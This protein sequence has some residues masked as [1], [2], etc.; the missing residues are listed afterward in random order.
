MQSRS[1]A[2]ALAAIAVAL[3][4]GC[5]GG[6]DRA[7]DKAGGASAPVVLRLGSNDQVG[8][9]S[10]SVMRYFAAE[11]ARL[12]HGGLRL[13]VR[14]DAGGDRTPASE[15]R[16]I[17]GVQA[18]RFDLG[19]IGARAWDELGVHS[20]EALQAPFLIRSHALLD[21]V[22]TSPL[23][24]RMLAGLTAQDVVGLALVPDELRHPIGLK[25]P[26]VA[27]GDFRRARF[28]DIP[29]RVTDELLRALGARPVHVA[30]IA[31]SRMV[32]HRQLDGEE[33]ALDLAGS[34]SIVT[35][36]A[37]FFGKALTLFAGRKAFDSLTSEQQRVVRTA[38]ARTLRHTLA[39]PPWRGALARFCANN[40]RVVLSSKRQLA[41]LEQ[42]THPV[43]AELQRDSQ[44]K[45]MIAAIRRLKTM[46]R[47]D[48]PLL[49]PRGCRYRPAATAAAGGK[50][51]SPSIVNGT[52]HLLF[53]KADALSFGDPATQPENMKGYPSVETRVL[54]DGK[55]RF[56]GGL[57]GTYSIRGN[58]ITLVA[59]AFGSRES[60]TFSF[61]DGTLR[62]R[63]VLPMDRGDQW[64]DAGE[65]WHR[66]GPPSALP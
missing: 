52:Y 16:I 2:A 62:L 63:P 5:S 41:G 18:G 26:F 51:R 53:T 17:R 43:Y 39:N 59:P 54:N 25:H 24:A 3:L 31:I 47:P 14:L 55:W 48:P 66:V 36:N 28:R 64:V 60:F 13:H 56:G 12:S 46:T 50:V 58:R 40:G 37:T 33:V 1:F 15:V 19:W 45:A 10:G 44:T 8:Q 32:G 6:H 49:V 9:P 29:S 42:A 22:T 21:R 57:H 7:S 11:V 38:A 20:F 30:N 61:Y 4:A 27:P 34:G 65:P 35:A 23:A